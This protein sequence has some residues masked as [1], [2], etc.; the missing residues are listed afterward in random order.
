L[1]N[2]LYLHDLNEAI[3]RFRIKVKSS[4]PPQHRDL[5]PVPSF[6]VKTARIREGDAIPF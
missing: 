5:E 2:I 1:E 3:S 4:R 6:L